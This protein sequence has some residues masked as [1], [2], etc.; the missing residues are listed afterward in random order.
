MGACGQ[1][2]LIA[3][4]FPASK[5]TKLWTESENGEEM[6]GGAVLSVTEKIQKRPLGVAECE[7]KYH[8][9]AEQCKAHWS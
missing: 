3:S 2:L 9:S 4:I 8:M 1:S 5:D 6:G 7:G